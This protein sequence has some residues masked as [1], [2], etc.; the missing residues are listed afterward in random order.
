MASPP[1]A[2]ARRVGAARFARYECIDGALFP[3]A[4]GRGGAVKKF[5]TWL[6]VAFLIFYMV[7]FPDH[8]ANIARGTWHATVTVAH[9]VGGFLN[10]LAS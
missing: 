5:V 1:L 8:A 7:T 3:R 6:I 4:L 9:G 2:T 10:R